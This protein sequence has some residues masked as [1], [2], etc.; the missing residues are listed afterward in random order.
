MW[1]QKLCMA[2]FRKPVGPTR[3]EQVHLIAEAGFDAYFLNWTPDGMM[4]GIRAGRECGLELQSVHAPFTYAAEFWG[5]EEQAAPAIRDY[6]ACLHD[7]ADVGAPI[8][9][10][11]PYKG[12]GPNSGPNEAGVERFLHLAEEAKHLGVKLAAENVEGEDYL[13]AW[14]DAAAG[15]PTVGFCWD[16][17]HEMC[18]NHSKDMLAVYG[19]R[20]LCTHLN[21]NLGIRAYDGS[22]LGRDDL[23]LL[24]FDGIADWMYNAERLNRC[25]FNG[26]LTFELLNCSKSGRHDNDFYADLP[27]KQYYAMAYQRACRVAALRGLW[28]RE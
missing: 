2:V 24:P 1:K 19:D 22:I 17:G 3:V 8:M 27:L 6:T 21:D 9:V 28:G 10:L 11:H 7:C 14:M 18:Y 15:D 23:H 4:P 25:G 12:F 5:T 20:L 16:S 13:A 26:I